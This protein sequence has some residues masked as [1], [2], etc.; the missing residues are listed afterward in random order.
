MA[1]AVVIDDTLTI[2][3]CDGLDGFR[4]WTRS[5]RFSIG[6]PVS[7]SLGGTVRLTK[8]MTQRGLQRYDLV[9]E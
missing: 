2:P 1:T 3:G 8:T 6:R 4:G 7:P 5:S 9:I